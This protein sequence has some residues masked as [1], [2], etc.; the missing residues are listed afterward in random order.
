MILLRKVV[1]DQSTALKR[2]LQGD[3]V[4]QLTLEDVDEL[5]IALGNELARAGIGP[6]GEINEHGLEVERLIDVL[7]HRRWQLD[8][9]A[10]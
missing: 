8:K 4:D 10:S 9:P 7:M 6:D 5:E 3:P 2:L 1:S